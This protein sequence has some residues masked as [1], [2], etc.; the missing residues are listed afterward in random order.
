MLQH[1]LFSH[2]LWHKS[3]HFWLH[4]WWDGEGMCRHRN[5]A[6]LIGADS[7]GSVNLT[8]STD[9][10]HRWSQAPKNNVF[11][12]KEMWF[13]WNGKYDALSLDLCLLIKDDT[14]SAHLY[15][16]IHIIGGN[17]HDSSD[18]YG[19]AKQL[20]IASQNSS[21]LLSTLLLQVCL[22]KTFKEWP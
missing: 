11:T 22:N 4:R 3:F 14:L 18:L 12:F 1:R 17:T 8:R 21:L 19:L 13:V 2:S 16:T 15:V 20:S 7:G 6:G 10:A 5:N 9:D